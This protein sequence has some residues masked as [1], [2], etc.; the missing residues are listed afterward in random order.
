M[1]LDRLQSLH[2]HLAKYDRAVWEQ[3]LAQIVPETHSVDQ[4]ATRI[5]FAFFPLDLHVRLETA[6]D[7]AVL[8]R[9]LGLMGTW[10]L[11]DQVDRSHQFLYGHRYWPQVNTAIAS[12][13]PQADLAALTRMVAD[14]AARTA[15]VD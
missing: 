10:R 4:F 14:A 8:A 2:Q 1:S 7:P 3:A 12:V 15:R 11:A 9:Q 5:W 6:D 13:D